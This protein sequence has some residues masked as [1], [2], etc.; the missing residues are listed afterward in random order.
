MK[1]K[2]SLLYGLYLANLYIIF[3]FWADNSAASLGS[4]F[5]ESLIALARLSALL[6]FYS[7][8]VQYTLISRGRWIEER[9]GLDKLTRVHHWNGI[10]A[11]TL[12]TAHIFLIIGGYALVSGNSY[13]E[14]DLEF[15]RAFPYVWMS[16]IAYGVL[17]TTVGLS[18]T[19]AKKRL[20]Y[21][22]WYY[23]HLLNYSVVPLAFWHQLANGGDLLAS[24]TFRSYWI[25]LTILSMLNLV[26]YRFIR[27]FW[28]YFRFRFKVEKVVK[29]TPTTSSI[30]ITGRNIERFKYMPGQFNK[31]WFVAKGYYWEEHPFTISVEPNGKYLRLTPKALG[32]FT[33]KLQ[34]IKPGSPVVIDGA[35]GIFTP[36][37]AKTEQFLFIAGG[38]GITP[39][40]AMIGS[41]ATTG[42]D[43]RLLYSARNHDDLALKSELD[44]FAKTTKLKID[45]ILAD[46]DRQGFLHGR[47]DGPTMEHLVPDFKTRDVYICGPPPMM[48]ALSAALL[49]RS[50]PKA[51]LHMERFSL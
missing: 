49:G 31:W 51:Q 43:M 38:I 32:D 39:L 6:G 21:E 36:A 20:R 27:P 8:L 18:I 3:Y 24:D 47:L 33:T 37:V 46:E 1:F 17:L 44:D 12:I 14:Q 28:L 11:L 5:G 9:F 19:I 7:I 34:N 10:A 30:Y 13:I 22:F 42:A 41:L 48:E 15:L 2:R 16:T 35:Y 26:V 45:Y 25:I 50:L 4:S 40:R 23:V 29:E